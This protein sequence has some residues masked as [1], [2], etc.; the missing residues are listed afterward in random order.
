M[1]FTANKDTAHPKLKTLTAHS[2]TAVSRLLLVRRCDVC[3]WKVM[4]Y[5][6]ASINPIVGGVGNE[7]ASR[8]S[9]FVII[10]SSL[11]FIAKI[12]S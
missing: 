9:R 10:S 7:Q 2:P 11:I 12:V 5:Q 1:V 3:T 8:N 4:P 6:V